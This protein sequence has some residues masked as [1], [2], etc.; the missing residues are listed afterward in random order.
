MTKN[1]QKSQILVKN[2]A[3]A[4][5][6]HPEPRTWGPQVAPSGPMG[7]MGPMGAHGGPMG[8]PWGPMGPHGAPGG[9]WG[10]LGHLSPRLRVGVPRRGEFFHQ[11]LD[12]FMIFGPK[13]GLFANVWVR[14][15]LLGQC[16]GQ[17]LASGPMFGPECGFWEADTSLPG[18][19]RTA[20]WRLGCPQWSTK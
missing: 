18:G 16:L 19:E 4:R 17:N 3:P 20:I 14:I 11:I 13:L 10:P 9:L 12:F 2:N 15:W 1:Q 8:A 7:P 6:A 5:N